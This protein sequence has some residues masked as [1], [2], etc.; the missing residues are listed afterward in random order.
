MVN[1]LDTISFHKRSR[2]NLKL[3]RMLAIIFFVIILSLFLFDKNF[4]VNPLKYQ[5][6]ILRI[7][8][9]GFI[10][11]DRQ[12]AMKLDEIEGN[13]NIK[14]IILII[15]SPGGTSFGGEF[16]FRKLNNLSS[17]GIP[18]VSIIRTIGTS[19]AY[20]VALSGDRIFAL[21]TSLVGSVGALIRSADLSELFNKVGI[22]PEIFKSGEFKSIPSPIEK[23]PLEGKE[24]IQNSVNEVKNWFLR[25]IQE[26]RE[27]SKKNLSG[28]SK[29]GVYTGKQALLINLVDEI[30]GEKEALIWLKDIKG[31]TKDL[32]I[33]D[34]KNSSKNQDFCCSFFSFFQKF[35][36]SS[37]VS[38]DGFLSVW[39]P[40]G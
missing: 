11:D 8:V 3:W 13:K 5:D 12:L 34:L 30:G 28:I 10:D 35:L 2:R 6:H 9:E 23:T 16:L 26:K 7:T 1:E 14:A 32:P 29:G 33:I 40:E 21:E 19:A 37:N 24:V 38:L 15:D 25:I 20:A 22:K 31:I 17:S 36:Y 4:F 39:H 27:I 18:V